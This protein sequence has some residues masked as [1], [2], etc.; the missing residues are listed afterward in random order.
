MKNV[1]TARA[2]KF[3]IIAIV[4]IKQADCCRDQAYFFQ[5]QNEA[6]EKC[7]HIFPLRTVHA[8]FVYI[9]HVNFRIAH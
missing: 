1:M 8:Q 5:Q 9:F 4:I 7:R 6:E 3:E 2:K